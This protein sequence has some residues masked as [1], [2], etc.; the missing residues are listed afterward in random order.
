MKELSLKGEERWRVLFREGK[1]LVG[2][3]V[4]ENRKREE[5][6][7]LER[8]DHP[9]L[10]YLVGG[11]VKLVLESEGKVMEVPLRKDSAVVVEEWHNAY[12]KGRVLVVEREGVKTEFKTLTQ[13]PER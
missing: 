11:K 10:F 13:P 1:W 9:E 12:G 7:K 6:T 5:V 4:P 3:Y 8:H 2:L